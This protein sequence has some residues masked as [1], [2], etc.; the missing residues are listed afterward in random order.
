LTAAGRFMLFEPVMAARSAEHVHFL[1]RPVPF[2]FCR[3]AAFLPAA[4]VAELY[5]AARSA[6]RRTVCA[7]LHASAGNVKRQSEQQN[8]HITLSN[9][10]VS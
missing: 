10:R 2:A 6:N 3:A 4:C 9:P 1:K 8:A 7:T 5:P